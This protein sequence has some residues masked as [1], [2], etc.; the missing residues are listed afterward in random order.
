MSKKKHPNN[1]CHQTLNKISKA[2]GTYLSY[3][4]ICKKIKRMEAS[5]ETKKSTV[6]HWVSFVIWM[7]VLATLMVVYREFFWLALP[8]AITSFA[9]GMDLL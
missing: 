7:G 1:L 6:R 9:R 4:Y 8:G 5:V 2:F 3:N